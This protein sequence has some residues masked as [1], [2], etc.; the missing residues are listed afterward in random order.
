MEKK[1]II[2]ESP[3]KANTINKYVGDEYIVLSSIGHIRDLSVS[4]E[5]G[6]GVDVKNNFSPTYV[7]IKGKGKVVTQLQSAAKKASQVL[8][9]TDPDR[10][11]EAIAWH[12][13][14]ILKL[15][16]NNDNRIVF[17]EITKPAVL[18]ALN[19]ARK[20]DM[21][22][23][24]SQETRRIIDRI[25]GF[26]LSSLLRNKIK[27][28][29]AGRV[30]SVALKLICDREDEINAFIPVEYYDVFANI[31]SEPLKCE[32]ILNDRLTKK[33]VASILNE[34]LPPFILTNI[35]KKVSKRSPKSPFTTS[36]L[37]QEISNSLGYSPT[38]TM[39]CAQ[40]LY[41]G[42]EING[43]ITGLITYMRT[44]STRLSD[45]FVDK[46][47]EMIK[48]NYGEQYLGTYKVKK[49]INAQD[50]HEAIR[51]TDLSLTPD[52]VRRYVEE[53]EARVYEKIYNRAVSS[54]MA[55]GLF[56]TIKYI[57]SS[58]KYKFVISGITPNFDGFFKVWKY[59]MPKTKE[60]PTYLVSQEFFGEVISEQ[61]FTKPK[62][63]Y[64]EA[65]L[66]SDLEDYGI[67][68]PSTYASTIKTIKDRLYVEKQEKKLV[69]T[70]QGMKTTKALDKFFNDIINVDYTKNLEEDLDLISD[71]KE[72]SLKVLEELY[73]KFEPLLINAH[74]NMEKESP[75][76][77]EELCPK[78][79]ANL[80]YRISK[81]G[82]FL[83]CSAFP[84]C[85]YIKENQLSKNI[86]NK[87]QEE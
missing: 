37:Q 38:K 28:R 72:E 49:N 54:L 33:E 41:E 68:R 25:L 66:I 9:A 52:I 11:G 83:A 12:L 71:G 60:L 20:I 22:L 13:A 59:D 76:L 81:Y 10:E 51:P 75:E 61:K 74:T 67:G 31:G 15:D 53:Q 23:V 70:E 47:L 58:N 85:R 82:K 44:D 45:I 86:A 65:S 46:C 30:Q 17:N 80:V 16:L 18:E 29:S 84:K 27:S 69:P 55:E 35:E 1:L 42:V 26:K 87:N 62:P 48:T 32:Y 2:V 36:T 7:T 21:D 79:G 63:R 19:R 64:T 14:S 50:A 56:D 24:N 39:I 40:N 4:G 8:I 78:C 43:E 57:F 6:L 77:S 73:E 3:S 5:G 34:A